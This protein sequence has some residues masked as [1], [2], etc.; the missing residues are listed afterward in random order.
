MEEE[1]RM[2]DDN[3]SKQDDLQSLRF[4]NGQNISQKSTIA[5]G[6]YKRQDE[7]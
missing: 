3:R 1:T 5:H 7:F 6:I 2:T 4:P